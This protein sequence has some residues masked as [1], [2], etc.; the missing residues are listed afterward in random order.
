VV[1]VRRTVKDTDGV[2][3]RRAARLRDRVRWS[4]SPPR[5]RVEEA[6]LDLATSCADEHDAFEHLARPVR[7]RAT[8]AQRLLDA[9]ATRP[10]ARRRRWLVDVL[11]DLRDGS[12][13]VLEHAYLT[14]VEPPHGLPQG[15]RQQAET[16]LTGRSTYRDV[17]Y[18]AYGTVVEL[19]GRVHDDPEQRDDDLDR[20]L[21]LAAGHRV[22]LRLG[23]GQVVARGCRTALGVAAVLE[24]RGWPGPPTP[25]GPECAVRHRGRRL[26]RG[27]RRRSRCRG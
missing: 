27:R 10:R 21:G 14:R 22:T 18:P 9:L 7:A 6:T 17:D 5:L 24:A 4:A 26:S 13:S 19:D 16:R 3:V 15:R 8:T 23:W 12:C 25:C 11:T 20:D 1:D 2:S